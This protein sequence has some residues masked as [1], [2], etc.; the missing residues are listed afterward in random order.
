M[1]FSFKFTM[2]DFCH[3]TDTFTTVNATITINNFDAQ[4]CI[5][6]ELIDKTNT[7]GCYVVVKNYHDKQP[8]VAIKVLAENGTNFAFQ[9]IHSLSYGN[10]E[11]LVFDLDMNGNVLPNPSFTYHNVTIW[12]IGWS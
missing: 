2:I 4:V 9:C 1:L 3:L 12:Q 10:Y 5:T 6:C 11:L 7:I 8:A